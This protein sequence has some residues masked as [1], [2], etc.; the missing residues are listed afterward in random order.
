MV[1]GDEPENLQHGLDLHRLVAE[2]LLDEVYVYPWGFGKTRWDF[3]LAFIRELCHPVGIPFFAA[4]SVGLLQD[5]ALIEQALS[6][7]AEGAASIVVF[8]AEHLGM[9]PDLPRWQTVS[10]MGHLDELQAR[11]DL[12]WDEVP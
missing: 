1:L 2:G 10:R 9:H 8:D 6:R 7:Y 4:L 11:L 3:G 5:K 12:P